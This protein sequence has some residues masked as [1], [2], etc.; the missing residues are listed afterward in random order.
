MCYSNTTGHTL[1]RLPL[2]AHVYVPDTFPGRHDEALLGIEPKS[3]TYLVYIQGVPGECARLRE[4]FLMLK[5]TDITQN[6]Y[7]Q[8]WT[9]TEIMARE[10]GGFLRFQIL[11]T[12]QLIRHVTMLVS[13]RVNAVFT[14]P[15]WRFAQSAMLRHRGAFSCIVL[16]TL[17]TSMKWVEVFL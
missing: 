10:K 16:V 9:V 13:L 5:Y 11:Q 3:A 14:V 4:G 2:N 7:I 1:R 12:A 17:R 8:S 15:A 6:T